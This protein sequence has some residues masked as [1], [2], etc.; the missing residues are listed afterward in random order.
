MK[1]KNIACTQFA[2]VRD[3]DVSFT[4]GLNVIYSIQKPEPTFVQE[5]WM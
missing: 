3:Q 5:C 1:I 4:D 2:G